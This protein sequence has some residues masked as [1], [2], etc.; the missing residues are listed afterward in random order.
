MT[1]PESPTQADNATTAHMIDGKY[2]VVREVLRDNNVTVL[3]VRAGT[4][5][6]R[7][8]AWFDIANPADRKRF[9]A[10]RSGLR[11]IAPTGLT[12]IVA[13]PGAYYAV[14]QPVNGTPLTDLL[15][16][17]VKKQ[18]SIEAVERLAE[19]L[20]EHGFAL[21]DADIVIEADEPNISYLRPPPIERKAEDIQALNSGTLSALNGGRIRKKRKPA[22]PGAWLLFVPGLLFLG[23]AIYMFTQT[24]NIYLNPPM[25]TI[26]DV[27]GKPAKEA[28]D[29][30]AKQNFQIEYDYDDT[31]SVPLGAVI[32][33]DPGAGTSLSIGRSVTLVINRPNLREVPIVENLTTKL[34]KDNLSETSFVIGKAIP[35]DGTVTKTP[36]GR[37]IAQI[38]AGKAKAQRGKS[39]QVL[40]STGIKGKMTYVPP[41][42]G[43]SFE[44]ARE[45]ARAAGLVVTKYSRKPSN[46]GENIVLEQKPEPFVLV[47]ENSGVTLVISQA[48]YAAPATPTGNIPLPPPPAPDPQLPE[49]EN[50]DQPLNT[51]L[52]PPVSPGAEPPELPSNFSQDPLV[53]RPI[54]FKYVFPADLPEGK[55]TAFVQDADGER[56]IME[57]TE[58][59][60]LRGFQANSTETVRGNAVFVIRANGAEY[61]RFDAE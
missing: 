59:S 41:L 30:V 22:E 10:Y 14:W 35:V 34:A 18:E 19:Q 28:A 40:V 26:P 46:K 20:A 32:R 58:A 44:Q 4:G 25:H 3:D 21:P 33:Q 29:I 15:S 36:K 54:T 5:S 37:I 48:R 27:T 8:V 60:R 57:A 7:R 6:M 31:V 51:P 12:D 45:N 17:S 42:L 61:D 16:Q 39:L 2:E 24:S 38:P 53:T 11:A 9:Y 56:M 13:R 50:G 1:G 55:Y 43:M 52:N 47:E 23:A 49:D